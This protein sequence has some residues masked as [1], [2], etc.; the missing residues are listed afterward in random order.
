[1]KC[2]VTGVSGFLGGAVARAAAAAGHDVVGLGRR[3]EPPTDVP[4]AYEQVDFSS[5]HALAEVVR[6]A[7]P[8]CVLHF[9]GAASVG[10]SLA[11]PLADFEASTLLWYRLLDAVRRSE[12]N[13]LVVL[14][15]SAAVYGSPE[16]LPTPETAPL[17]PESP[18]G[19]HKV[20]CELA[21]QE[22]A[23]C[24]GLRVAA[25]RYFSIF[26]PRQRRLLVWEIFEQL[27]KGTNELHLKGTG[28]EQRDYL[29]ED[30]A[31]GMTVALAEALSMRKIADFTAFN[32]ASGKSVTVR[33]VVE[34]LC[35]CAGHSPEIAFGSR[36]IPGNP[37][38]W[39]A[40]IAKLRAEL[41][42]WAAAPFGDSLAK[43]VL[44]WGAGKE[45]VE[46]C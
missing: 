12:T 34:A 35:K 18:Y 15:S 23:R 45:M 21:G 37:S 27:R 40:D 8:D 1:M 41:S 42:E 14:A 11:N 44:R 20:M 43:C 9:A 7:R 28:D 4:C 22:F 3:A 2:L 26:G 13:P 31:A 30:E 32:V 46:K 16:I 6:A 39:Q 17:R 19:F 29:A 36:P 10:N 33:A 25:F 24:F 38:R 5:P